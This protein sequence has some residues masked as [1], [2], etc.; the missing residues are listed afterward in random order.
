MWLMQSIARLAGPVVHGFKRGSKLLGWC[1]AYIY[2]CRVICALALVTVTLNSLPVARALT[3]IAFDSPAPRPT[4]NLGASDAELEALAPG[5]SPAQ[6]AA[7]VAVLLTSASAR[8][9]LHRVRHCSW[10]GAVQGCNQRGACLLSL[11]AAVCSPR[12][13]DGTLSSKTRRRQSK[14]ICCTSSTGD[15]AARLCGHFTV[16]SSS[17]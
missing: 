7:P 17:L 12:L 8:R 5:A 4:A 6:E 2:L 11:G 14:R 15:A 9:C 3:V 1:G 13:R 16:H 10:A